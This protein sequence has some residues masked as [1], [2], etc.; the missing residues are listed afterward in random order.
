MSKVIRLTES[1]LLKL[2]KNVIKEQAVSYQK[3]CIG[4]GTPKSIVD[5]Y[6][7]L[8]KQGYKCN[9]NTAD[10]FEMSKNIG[11]GVLYISAKD[12]SKRTRQA[13]G[14]LTITFY[15]KSPKGGHEGFLKSIDEVPSIEKMLSSNFKM[16]NNFTTKM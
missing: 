1:D 9:S 10:V 16:K 15:F 2:V 3:S 5:I 6:N 8:S 7:K 11:V 14:T 12:D 13:P 4:T